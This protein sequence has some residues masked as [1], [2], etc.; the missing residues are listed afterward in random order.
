MSQPVRKL[1]RAQFGR[2][3]AP[4]SISSLTLR[5]GGW[6]RKFSW[7]ARKVFASAAAAVI[8]FTSA[9]F[10]PNGFCTMVGMRWLSVRFTSGWWVRIWVTMSTS[11]SFSLNSMF[12]ASTYQ[13]GTPNSRAARL[14]LAGVNIAD[15]DE[16]DALGL[17]V[18]PGVEVVAG[19]EA[20]PD[21]AN[22]YAL[23]HDRSLRRS[24]GI[25]GRAFATAGTTVAQG[26]LPCVTVRYH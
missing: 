16:I 24:V 10:W 4:V 9:M 7:T 15:G 3:I 12:S 23:R 20:A 18:P 19:K 1:I 22:C 26:F 2:P 8:A 5:S 21:D 17:E 14:G 13:L 11:P 6:K 25:A